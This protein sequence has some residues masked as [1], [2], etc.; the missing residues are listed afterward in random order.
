MTNLESIYTQLKDANKITEVQK[1]SRGMRLE[2]AIEDNWEY[3]FFFDNDKLKKVEACN[4]RELIE[5]WN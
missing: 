5:Q 1:L 4:G 3:S 2:K